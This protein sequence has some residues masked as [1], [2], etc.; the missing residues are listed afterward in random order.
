ME[1]IYWQLTCKCGLVATL[2]RTRFCLNDLIDFIREL[3]AF[4]VRE[5]CRRALGGGAQR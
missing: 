2:R 3:R 1:V 4:G 5:R